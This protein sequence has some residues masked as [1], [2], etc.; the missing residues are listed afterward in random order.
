MS[1]VVITV[2]T[3]EGTVA[4]TIDGTAV[5]GVKN[6]YVFGDKDP[7]VEVVSDEGKVGDG[8]RKMTR[9]V[10]AEKIEVKES[11][12]D[13]VVDGAFELMGRDRK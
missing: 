3:V 12:A 7:Y 11:V 1:K 13:A 8:L 6:A 2:D 10:T 9:I 5:E 4:C